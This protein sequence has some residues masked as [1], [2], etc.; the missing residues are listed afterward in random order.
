MRKVTAIAIELGIALLTCVISPALSIAAPAS[1]PTPTQSPPQ[2][3]SATITGEIIDAGT[4]TPLAGALVILEPHPGGLL[5]APDAGGAFMRGTLRVE[6]GPDGRYSFTDLAPGE[7]RVRVRLLGYHPT[8]VQVE[9]QEWNAAMVSVALIVAPIALQPLEVTVG[10]AAPG[11][12]YGRT[13]SS[14]PAPAATEGAHRLEI[15]RLR[16]RLHL[17]PDTRA[18]THSDIVE[19]VTLGETD[20][21]RAL[22]HFPGMSAPDDYSAELQVRGAPWDQTRIYFDGVPIYNP[23]HAAGLLSGINTDAVGA[24]FLHPGVQPVALGG[25]AAGTLDLRSRRGEGDDGGAGLRGI[26]E[27]SLA[28][29]RLALDG[30][31]RAGHHRWLVAG[32]RTYLDWLTRV[33]ERFAGGDDIHVPYAFYDLVSR[34]DY[35][36]DERRALEVSAIAEFDAVGGDIPDVLHRTGA[37][38]GGGGARVTLAT[39]LAGL[40][41]RHTLGLSGTGVS[42]WRLAP[43]SALDDRYSAPD[44]E[45]VLHRLLHLTLGGE[46]SPAGSPAGR[47]RPWSAGYDLVHQ[48]TGLRG[49]AAALGISQPTQ[50]ALTES[51][52]LTYAVLWG[53]RRWS[54]GRAWTVGM[55]L[56]LEGGAPVLNGGTIRLA[57]RLTARYALSPIVSLS[58]AAGRAYQ[59]EQT[60]IPVGVAPAPGFHSGDLWILAGPSTPA[61]RADIATLGAEAWLHDSWL[62]AANAYFRRT[63]GIASVDPTP[64][65]LPDRPLRVSGSGRARGVELSLRRLAGRLTSSFAYTYALSEMSA[66]GYTFP[67]PQDR[68]HALAT[69][70][71]LR[72]GRGWRLGAAYTAASGSAYTRTFPGTLECTTS[73]DCTWAKVPWI[74]EPGARRRPAIRRLDLLLDWNRQFRSWSL[75]GFMQLRN[76]LGHDNSGRYTG[77]GSQYCYSD[78]NCWPQVAEDGYYDEFLT[79]LPTLPLIGFRVAF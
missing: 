57:P 65:T 59:Y 8:T 55:G 34:Y 44:A 35:Q 72:A 27:L 53:E 26:G 20:L 16:Q 47:P 3:G 61:L 12:T 2:R 22:Q 33:V 15:E 77:S 52:H 4:E 45:P 1:A 62:A 11:A 14:G 40:A 18:V 50:P 51:D 78:G 58:A 21:F 37:R 69:T 25:G 73:A 74:G 71:L 75:G 43:D 41:T 30:S 9:L 70:A 49:T 56:R 48:R 29:A 38:W 39:P 42:T 60:I 63:T 67:A 7:Y 10:A 66:S 13:V 54:P 24:A 23:L 6:T 31:S 19:G 28:S 17:T 68:R 5:P 64:G 76:A 46:L 79:G 32:R 36:L